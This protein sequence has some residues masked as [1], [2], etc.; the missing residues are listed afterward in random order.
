MKIKKSICPYDCPTSCGLVIETDGKKILK[1]KGDENHPATQ[2][3]ICRKMRNYEESVHSKDRILTPL[4][5]IGK[6]GEGKFEKMEV[7]LWRTKSK[8][9]ASAAVHV[10]LSAR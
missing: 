8:A 7:P 5:R 3:L 4:K 6:K 2:G 1:V 10:K 9:I